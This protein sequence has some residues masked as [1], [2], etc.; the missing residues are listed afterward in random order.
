MKFIHLS[1]LHLGKRV[2]EF[3]M[4]EDQAHALRQVLAVVDEEKPDAVLL[5]GD[6]YDKG[7]PSLEA[8]RL[9]DYFLTELV[10]R[11]VPVAVISGNHDSPDRLEF[12]SQ[13]LR[14]RG[15]LIAGTPCLPLQTLTLNDEHGP[16]DIVL[17][18]FIK[19]ALVRSLFSEDPPADYSGAVARM[20]STLPPK[21]GRRVLVA[22]QFV[23]AAG[24][25]PL[26][27]DSET[28]S[29]GGVDNVDASVFDG[30]DYVALGHIHRPQ[31]MGR[32]TVRYGGSLLKYSFSE[33]EQ[34][35]GVT[36]AELHADGACTIRFT[37]LVPLH[38]MRELRGPLHAL[39]SPEIADAGNKN[40]YLSVTLTDEEEL[41]DP[42]GSL[43]A[44]YPNLMKLQ[45]DNRR[46]AAEGAEGLTQEELDA[47]TGPRELFC[48]FF[49]KQN[50]AAPD[51]EQERLL[52]E[53]WD[54]IGGDKL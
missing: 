14:D 41:L 43:R 17:L 34:Q 7:V 47:R 48:E 33:A 26:A 40:D 51:A 45:Y 3:S 46:T 44:V 6:V 11:R 29:I 19:P 32:E 38:D 37:P 36:I 13:V 8:V 15:V 21:T 50:G 28:V 24:Q 54:R 18:P 4:T 30:F 23:T 25:Q 9:L 22:H 5:A 16:V 53:I 52:E 39:L 42:I 1:D 31:P 12:L 27:S 49:E 2:G 10:K 35:K 20:L